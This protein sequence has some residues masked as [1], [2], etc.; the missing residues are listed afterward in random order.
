MAKKSKASS[1]PE[2]TNEPHNA[3]PPHLE[4]KE[5]GKLN[6]SEEIRVEAKRL[7]DQGGKPTPKVIIEILAKRGV[8]VVSP[9]VSQVLK[10]MGMAQR[11]RKRKNPEQHP[12]PPAACQTSANDSF[13]IHELIAAKKFAEMVGSPSKARGLLDALDKLS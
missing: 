12:K 11:T 10:K 6:K 13:T 4:S 9:Q 8:T 7:M 1:K 2:I 5:E 3:A